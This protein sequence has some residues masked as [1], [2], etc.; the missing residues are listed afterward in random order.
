MRDLN[1]ET[2]TKEVIF[3]SIQS[4]FLLLGI[5]SSFRNDRIE[6]ATQMF[7]HPF[8]QIWI[9]ENQRIGAQSILDWE[10]CQGSGLA[11]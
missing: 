2:L 8:K 9:L 3:K 6:Q 11:R 1:K 10:D 5:G 4:Q 7:P